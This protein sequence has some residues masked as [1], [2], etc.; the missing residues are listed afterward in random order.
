[1]YGPILRLA[2]R[3]IGSNTKLLLSSEWSFSPFTYPPLDLLP[4]FVLIGIP[5]S[6]SENPLVL[7]LAGHELGHTLWGT[8]KLGRT[9]EAQVEDEMLTVLAGRLPELLVIAPHTVKES[10]TKTD[11]EQNIFVKKYIASSVQWAL[12]QVQEYFCDA[13]GLFLF[14]EA[15]LHAHS[16]LL[17]PRVA[18]PRSLEYPS[19]ASRV[20]ALVQAA[21]RTFDP[22]CQAYT[23]SPRVMSSSSKTTKNRATRT[24]S[25]ERRSQIRRRP[26]L[27]RRSKSKLLPYYKLLEFRRSI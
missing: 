18:A 2:R 7:P 9:F 23:Q 10:D 11:L 26:A 5:A 4:N 14:D 12:R 1:M 25:L 6:E 21:A 13:V 16:Y 20:N 27:R 19:N 8:N 22:L 17:A 24:S 15:F 3:I